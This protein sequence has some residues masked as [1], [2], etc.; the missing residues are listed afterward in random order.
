MTEPTD[1][2]WWNALRPFTYSPRNA[3]PD[4]KALVALLRDPDKPLP[5]EFRDLLAEVL[6]SRSPE[7]TCNNWTL[8]P[9][10]VGRHDKE[11]RKVKKE[12]R[13]EEAMATA[14]NVTKAMSMVAGVS[15]RAAWKLRREI[16]SHIAG[17]N[18]LV[19]S[20]G[21]SDE[22]KARFQRRAWWRD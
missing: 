1:H 13:V 7:G 15:E 3:E 20:S 14:A 2:E 12:L 10:Y 9:K 22:Q 8:R 11:M 17:W 6:D 5:R 16:E 4:V 19:E 18:R 21:L